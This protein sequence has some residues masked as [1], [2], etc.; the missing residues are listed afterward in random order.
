MHESVFDRPH[1]FQLVER[2]LPCLS[3]ITYLATPD[4]ETNNEWV[5][6]LKPLCV[7]QLTRAPKIPRLRELRSLHMH[8]LDAHRL[9]YKLVPNPFIIVSLNNVKVA[10][11]KVKTGGHAVWDEEFTLE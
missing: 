7:S 4:A 11:T 2:A 6:A 8:I 9:P 5:N 10:R 3:T 1:C